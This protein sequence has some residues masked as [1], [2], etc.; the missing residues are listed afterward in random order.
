MYA[1]INFSLQTAGQSD[2]L[3]I[4]NE[5]KTRKCVYTCIWVPITTQAYYIWHMHICISVIAVTL[6]L[7]SDF[8]NAEVTACCVA[9]ALTTSSVNKIRISINSTTCLLTFDPTKHVVVTVF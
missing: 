1:S 2:D 7:Y 4:H 9:A 8:K 6:D 5:I 3:I